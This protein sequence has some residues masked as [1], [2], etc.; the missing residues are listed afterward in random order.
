VRGAGVP[1]SENVIVTMADPLPSVA[2][3]VVAGIGT[4]SLTCC[5]RPGIHPHIHWKRIGA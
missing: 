1:K 4:C 5:T 2:P 3:V